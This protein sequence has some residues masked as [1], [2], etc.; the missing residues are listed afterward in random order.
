MPLA[1]RCPS[2]SAPTITTWRG[3]SID[4]CA[5]L[6]FLAL[7]RSE[8]KL[9]PPPA[10]MLRPCQCLSTAEDG[11]A[12]PGGDA[13][14]DAEDDDE[15]EAFELFDEE[16]DEDEE[17]DEEEEE[18][19]EDKDMGAAAAA[20]G[21]APAKLRAAFLMDGDHP[22]VKAALAEK[23]VGACH[24]A[25]VDIFK[26]CASCLLAQAPTDLGPCHSCLHRVFNADARRN[27]DGTPS[28][29]MDNFL[30]KVFA[31]TN[32][33]SGSKKVFHRCLTH[34]ESALSTSF[35]RSNMLLGWKRS[36][37]FPW[38]LDVIFSKWAGFEFL[39]Q[40]ETD[41]LYAALEDMYPFTL[42]EGRTTDAEIDRV[43]TA[44][45]LDVAKFHQVAA[46]A[47]PQD[48]R[49]KKKDERVPNQQRATWMTSPG[50][51]ADL[52]AKNVAKEAEVVALGRQSRVEATTRGRSRGKKTSQH[53]QKSTVSRGTSCIG[54]C[55]GAAACGVTVWASGGRSRCLWCS[56]GAGRQTGENRPM[57]WRRLPAT[58]QSGRRQRLDGL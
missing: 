5:N 55:Q 16:N 26:L 53:R 18:E 2:G 52:V 39:T 32:I 27:H 34:V 38:D 37:F 47:A 31:K 43:M 29:A 8:I 20:A 57:Q 12:A 40:D 30:K 54:G 7:P 10:W 50:Y 42:A 11:D 17:D 46:A 9:T 25:H 24:D 45:G 44:H 13:K 14:E 28:P 1:P 41:K 51:R 49:S 6:S 23:F 56:G 4:M 3:F 36:G 58:L 15:E 35:S 19:E 22:Q 21:A 33:P 48:Q